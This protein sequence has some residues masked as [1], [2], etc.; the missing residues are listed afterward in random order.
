MLARLAATAGLAVLA[1]ASH[2][3]ILGVTKPTP[4]PAPHTYSSAHFLFHHGDLDAATIAA[5]AAAI[6]AQYDRVIADLAAG[7]MPM[8]HVTFHPDH[9]SLQNAVRSVAGTIPS[10]ASGLVIAADQIHMMSFGLPAWGPHAQRVTELVHEFAHAVSMRISPSVSNLPRWI[11]ETVAIY[12]ARQFVD[13][14][15]VPY[16]TSLQP[17][18]MV[19]LNAFDNTK[20]YDVGFVIAEFIVFR[21]G[22]S[23][24]R[25][26]IVNRGDTQA[27]LGMTLAEFEPAWF[28][29]AR[30]KYSF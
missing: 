10:W 2:G 9:A 22:Q 21:A 8:V 4:E 12:E 19:E 24:L 16:M 20:V 1:I 5:T 17:P 13:P 29:F 26:L 7:S 30:G 25:S 28:A 3:C 15:T 6:E 23:A 27:T 18:T 14:R 11:W